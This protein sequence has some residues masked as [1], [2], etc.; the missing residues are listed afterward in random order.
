MQAV[1]PLFHA[2]ISVDAHNYP[3]YIQLTDHPPVDEIDPV[4][5][6]LNAQ[7]PQ[8]VGINFSNPS[9]FLPIIWTFALAN[10]TKVS[11]LP[12][13]GVYF[14]QASEY[15]QD[16]DRVPDELLMSPDRDFL[17]P[18]HLGQTITNNTKF[19][20]SAVKPDELD[21]AVMY[22]SLLDPYATPAVGLFE[23]DQPYLPNGQRHPVRWTL[24]QNSPGVV[25][26]ERANLRFW[27]S[28]NTLFA[29]Y[30]RYTPNFKGSVNISIN[31]SAAS[32][33]TLNL[34]E[35]QQTL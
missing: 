16:S 6:S 29:T 25:N 22:P 21:Q 11:W 18:L 35:T 7:H 17:S 20:L 26:P 8:M 14:L 30:L 19:V 4:L 33:Q 12:G 23:G 34:A 10:K 2:V 5:A 3:Q 28:G 9:G 13:G 1:N 32:Q 31:G 24:Q 15:Y 27:A